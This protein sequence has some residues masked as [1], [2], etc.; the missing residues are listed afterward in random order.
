M[1]PWILLAVI[2]GCF[3]GCQTTDNTGLIATAPVRNEVQFTGPYLPASDVDQPPTIFEQ[4]PPE[5][6]EP[7]LRARIDGKAIVALI[8]DSSGKPQQVQCEEATHPLFADAAV[9]AVKKWRFKPATKGGQAVASNL[10]I[11][12]EFRRETVTD[13]DIK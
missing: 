3:A 4:T 1:K 11:P 2:A 13:I 10:S 7:M 8:V 9:K 5:F 12:I 6:P